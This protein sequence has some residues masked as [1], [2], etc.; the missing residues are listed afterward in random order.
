MFSQLCSAQ[1]ETKKVPGFGR[2]LLKTV[3]L[4]KVEL[5]GLVHDITEKKS[6]FLI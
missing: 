5:V 4:L 3:E 2:T 1:P 6:F